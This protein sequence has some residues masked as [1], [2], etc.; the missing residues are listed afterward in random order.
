MGLSSEPLVLGERGRGEGRPYILR[1][2]NGHS[3]VLSLPAGHDPW[4]A[5]VRYVAGTF[6]RDAAAYLD[7]IRPATDEDLAAVGNVAIRGDGSDDVLE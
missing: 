3:A 6:P 1:V 5:G 2:T 4:L 7:D